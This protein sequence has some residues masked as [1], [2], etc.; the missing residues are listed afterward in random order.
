MEGWR[1]DAR[2]EAI[3]ADLDALVPKDICTAEN[4]EGHG[5]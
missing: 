3:I 4:R 1:K 2:R 5:L